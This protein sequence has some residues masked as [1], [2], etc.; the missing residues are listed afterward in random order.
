LTDWFAKFHDHFTQETTTRIR[1]D[2]ILRN[3][4]LTDRIWGV[5]FEE[6]RLGRPEEDIASICTSL[7]STTPMFTPEKYYLCK[8]FIKSYIS[9]TKKQVSNIADE[10]AHTLL[11]QIQW[12]PDDE[13][14]L[15]LH[16]TMLR[17]KG[18]P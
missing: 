5:D 8:T 1:G 17:E 15:R 3:F 14:L 10:I 11:L 18:L 4:I 12:R 9:L 16:A 6:S 7:L 13:A 2:A